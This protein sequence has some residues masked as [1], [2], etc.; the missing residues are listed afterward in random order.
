MSS[1]Q[2]GQVIILIPLPKSWAEMD[3]HHV[4]VLV[5]GAIAGK[6]DAGTIRRPCGMDLLRLIL[7]EVDYLRAI[8]PHDEDVLISGSVTLEG[9]PLAVSRPGGNVLVVRA[10]GDVR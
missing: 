1:A 7:R 10:V 8:R 4:D 6:G 2:N 9:D 3:V 5:A